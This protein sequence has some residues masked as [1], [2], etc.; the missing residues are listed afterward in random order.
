MKNKKIINAQILEKG[1]KYDEGVLIE[2]DEKKVVIKFSN[3][4]VIL[5][6]NDLVNF[7]QS[8]KN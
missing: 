2:A 1:K 6:K 8:F 7:L 4:A 5:N 3:L